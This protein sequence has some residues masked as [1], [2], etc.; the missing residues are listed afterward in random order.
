MAKKLAS[1]AATTYL[2]KTRM[3]LSTKANIIKQQAVTIREASLNVQWSC[4][5]PSRTTG[6]LLPPLNTRIRAGIERGA[7]A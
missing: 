1:D 6:S 2:Q 3:D 4:G 5:L 7:V